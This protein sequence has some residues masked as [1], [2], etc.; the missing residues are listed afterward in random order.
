MGFLKT[1]FR[2]KNGDKLTPEQHLNQYT[3]PPHAFT[4]EKSVPKAKEEPEVDEEQQRRELN[5]STEYVR[6]VRELIREKYRLDVHIWSKRDTLENNHKLIM[7][8]CRRSDSILSEIYTIVSG[9][10][11]ELFTAEEWAV[12]RQIQAGVMRCTREDPWQAVPPWYRSSSGRVGVGA[13]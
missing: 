11:R 9:W 12:V 6:R 4:K 10:Q 8:S 3:A 5:A 13:Y 7:E 1:I 2:P